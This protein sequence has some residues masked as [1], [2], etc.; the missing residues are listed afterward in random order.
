MHKDNDNETRQSTVKIII[1]R[2]LLHARV[3]RHKPIVITF[4]NSH[5]R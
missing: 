3:S 4:S 5:L 1:V 2:A